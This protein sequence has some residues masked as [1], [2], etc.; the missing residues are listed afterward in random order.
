MKTTKSIAVFIVSY[1]ILYF[2]L[3]AIGCMFYK[4]PGDHYSYGECIGSTVWFTIYNLFIGW[5]VAGIVAH[6]Y[7]ESK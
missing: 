5:W 6:D 2:T 3:S 4:S 7:Y 1:F